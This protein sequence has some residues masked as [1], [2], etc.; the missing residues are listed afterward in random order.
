[1][2]EHEQAILDEQA[3]SDARITDE[4]L[5][6]HDDYTDRTLV[7]FEGEWVRWGSLTVQDRKAYWAD[8]YPF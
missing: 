1:M 4:A 8:G 3:L 5:P 2:T 6:N 7:K